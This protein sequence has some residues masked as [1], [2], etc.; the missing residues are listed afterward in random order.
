MPR[1]K[2]LGI[3]H[4]VPSRVVTNLDLEKLM[5]TSDEWIRQRTGIEERR[6]A[7]PGEATSDLALQASR[8]A[9]EAAGLTP[10]DIEMI[11]FATLSPDY[12][13]PG[14]GV[15]LQDKLGV[16]EIPALD[17]RQ[18]CSGF[19]YGLAV[20]DQFVRTGTFR[21]I[22]LVGAEV[23]S[24]GLNYTTEGRDIACI[25]GDGAA[26]VVLAAA[27]DDEEG[28]IATALHSQGK[29]HD[30]LWMEKPGSA[31][32]PMIT[33]EDLATGR[34]Y[35]RMEGQAVFKYATKRFTEVI[36]EVLAQT[37]YGME[38]VDLFVFHQANL[39]IIEMVAKT[40]RIPAEKVFNN[41]QRYGNTTAASIPLCLSE[42][43]ESGKLRKGDLVCLAAFG[44]GFTWASALV[45]W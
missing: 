11:V 21:H 3:G 13:F 8:R 19:V 22:L 40:M 18:Q 41:L 23:H 2:I 14:S 4:Y 27:D 36:P 34:Q 5:D 10:G 45:R 7:A 43:A 26:A 29:Y 39:R 30:L 44:S 9:I 6:V 37:K 17:I 1:T 35:P 25:F 15:L 42:A 24:P 31:A 12:Y 38:D 28:L 20:A 32:Q 16:A 33:N